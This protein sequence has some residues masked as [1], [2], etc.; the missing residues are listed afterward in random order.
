[1]NVNVE[2]LD[3]L[4]ALAHAD[5][6]KII[7]MLVQN[8]ATLSQVAAGLPLPTRDAYNHLA[9]LEYVGLVSENEGLYHLQTEQL[10]NCSRRSLERQP[11]EFTPSLAMEPGQQKVLAA[12]L[13]PDGTIRKIPNSI[14]QS[15]RFR[16][17]LDYIQAAFEPGRIYS[18]KEVN[19]VISRFHHDL[20][21][22]RRDL[23]EAGLLARERDGS[24]Y[25][26]VEQEAGK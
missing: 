22:L 14:H 25:W 21:G 20:S 12:F 6:L 1:M 18:E 19:A 16:L 17:V 15:A 10:E 2:M 8:P 7:G 24:K 11:P 26:R 13:N 5:R 9:F 23:V 4:K 3:L